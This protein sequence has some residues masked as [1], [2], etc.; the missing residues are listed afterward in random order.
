M[1][2]KARICDGK[3]VEIWIITGVA[4]DEFAEDW[5]SWQH[6]RNDDGTFRNASSSGFKAWGERKSY[7][8][9]SQISDTVRK[10]R[11]RNERLYSKA[12][13]DFKRVRHVKF[14]NTKS[15][16]GYCGLLEKARDSCKPEDRW[17]V[18]LQTSESLASHKKPVRKHSSKD[19]SVVAVDGEGDIF[20]VCHHQKDTTIYGSHLLAMA[21]IDGGTKLD[22]YDK[23]HGFYVRNGFEP[24]SWCKFDP[25]YAPKDCPKE[26]LDGT[27][28]PEDIIFYK[29]VGKENVTKAFEDKDV[30]KETVKC[31]NDYGE[32]KAVRDREL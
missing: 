1:Q 11:A 7:R 6:P 27:K 2:I 12:D 26:Y 18:D 29:Y 31:C 25:K 5:N 9:R 24:V 30:F 32:A 8:E 28:K 15:D 20:A 13:R 19:G 16:K 4:E 10:A 14:D 21:I 22:S 3:I 23:N 17:R